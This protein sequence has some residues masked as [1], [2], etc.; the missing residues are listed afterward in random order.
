MIS[1]I[2]PVYNA[3]DYLREAILSVFSQTYEDWELILV[4]DG[5]TDSSGKICDS[6]SSQSSKVRVTH[7]KNGGVSHAR[8]VGIDMATG[9]YITFLDADD[10]IP[11]NAFSILQSIASSTKGD[12]IC[13]RYLTFES[14]KDIDL[15]QYKKKTNTEYSS[16]EAVNETL[17]QRTFDNSV[18]AKLYIRSLWKDI[19]FRENIR[20]EDLDIFYRIFLKAEKIINTSNIVYLYRQH[21]DSY[22]HIF[23]LRRTDV[24]EVTDRLTHY[25]ADNYPNLLP[26][27]KDR[28]LSA[29]FNILGLIAANG[30]TDDPEASPIADACWEKIK[31]LRL[32]SL[33][34]PNVRLKNKIGILI[35]YL[36]GRN[37][38]EMLSKFVY[39][40]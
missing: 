29:N 10:V 40:N 2:V 9:E 14:Y 18:S 35:S 12:I 4:D 36:F 17:Y 28:Q 25:M 15:R 1:V 11:T 13:G 8:N 39:R 26:A 7:I 16:T 6:F 19:R 5:S 38:V 37:G 34:N 3:E 33:R 32:E 24:L 22:I 31:E 21:K 20:Y 30:M 23:N 27:A